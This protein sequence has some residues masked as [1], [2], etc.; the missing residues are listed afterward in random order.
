MNKILKNFSI[1]F[2]ATIFSSLLSFVFFPIFANVLNQENLGKLEFINS[3]KSLL[4]NLSLFGTGVY[5]NKEYYNSDDKESL[6]KLVYVFTLIT[7]FVF[8]IISYFV[9][10]IAKQFPLHVIIFICVTN[11]LE[12]YFSINNFIIQIQ[13]RAIEYCVVNILKPLIEYVLSIIVLKFFIDTYFGRILGN[14]IA[15]FII[16]L[17]I[18]YRNKHLFYIKISFEQ[19]LKML[20][21]GIPFVLSTIGSWIIEMSDKVFISYMDDF[22]ATAIYSVGYKMGMIVLFINTALSRV[23]TPFFYKNIKEH[24]EYVKKVLFR[25]TFIFALFI[26]LYIFIAEL[27]LP[28]LFASSYLPARPVIVIIAVGYFFDY[29]WKIVITYLISA[30]GTIWYN[31]SLVLSSLL[32]II[33]DYVLIH[34][35]GYLGAAYATA[36]SY[37]VGFVF[38]VVIYLV[39]YRRQY[40]T[41]S[42]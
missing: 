39:K 7:G 4:L 41:K 30:G 36:I 35:N 37:C 3:A 28:F 17:Y 23:L 18:L 29:L 42:L 40:E 32:N 38:C 24:H 33:L 11:I 6:C 2:V 25:T 1:Y 14:C 34:Y 16:C 19:L 9:F 8:S 26:I 22:T 31:T 27:L 12:V 10:L 21:F 15:S 5:I 13:E 20:F